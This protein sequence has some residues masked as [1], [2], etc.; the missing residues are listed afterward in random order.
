MSIKNTASS[1]LSTIFL[2]AAAIF[3]NLYFKVN[4]LKITDEM[5]IFKNAANVS[6]VD[7]A[8]SIP[9]NQAENIEPDTC[10]N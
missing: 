2:K 3:K 1:R 7:Q 8:Q 9:E 6:Y 4:T 5:A 10:T